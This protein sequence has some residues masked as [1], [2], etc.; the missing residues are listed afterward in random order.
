VMADDGRVRT[1]FGP[2]N[3]TSRFDASRVK[4]VSI[5]QASTQQNAQRKALIQIE[6]DRTVKF[7]AT[8]PDERRAWMLGALRLLLVPNRDGGGD[9]G[10]SGHTTPHLR[11]LAG[12]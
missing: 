12:R 6:A 1:G 11:P 10:R 4:R 9:A 3:R 7:G 8:L 5:G 2:F